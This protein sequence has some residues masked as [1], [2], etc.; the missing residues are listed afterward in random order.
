MEGT[1]IAFECCCC[2][3]TT[4]YCLNLGRGSWSCIK[5]SPVCLHYGAPRGKKS[6]EFFGTLWF[7][8]QGETLLWQAGE[9]AKRDRQSGQC[10]VSNFDMIP[11]LRF[12][13]I[14]LKLAVVSVLFC[15]L[16]SS[17]K[18][19]SSHGSGEQTR[20]FRDPFSKR[21]VLWRRTAVGGYGPSRLSLIVHQFGFFP[22]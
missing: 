15:S 19:T 3:P 22:D 21:A 4:N 2:C 20:C 10:K 9:E 13:P 12:R 18:K 14:F 7:S 16:V 11:A 5:L 1:Y 6:W 8:K 17:H